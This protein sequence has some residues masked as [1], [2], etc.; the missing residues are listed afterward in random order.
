MVVLDQNHIEKTDPVI[1]STTDFDGFFF[2][3]THAGSGFASV[4][5]LGLQSFEFFLIAGCSCCDTAHALHDV[6]H[7]ALGLEQ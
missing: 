3:Q 5:N 1:L 2:E 4:E 7:H 6:K